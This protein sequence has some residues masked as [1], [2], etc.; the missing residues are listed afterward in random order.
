MSLFQLFVGLF[1]LGCL[2]VSLLAMWRVA[3]APAMRFKPAWILGSLIGFLGFAVNG[4]A[5]NDLILQVG[6]QVPVVMV[7]R[8][9][10]DGPW[11]VK[12]LFP[13]IAVAALVR[14]RQHRSDVR[15]LT[16]PFE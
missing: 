10:P 15:S 12:A 9:G 6:I 14:A 13:L 1:G 8:V 7:S 4:S 5:P 2:V 11:L 3:K 16:E